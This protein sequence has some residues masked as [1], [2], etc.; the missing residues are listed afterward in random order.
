[1]EVNDFIS[2]VEK[3]FGFQVDTL[4]RKAND[5]A[6]KEVFANFYFSADIAGC[7]PVQS[8]LVL[9]GT[10]I[11]RLRELMGG[12][13]AKNEA[14]EDTM[15]DLVNYLM[16]LKHLKKQ[17]L[18]EIQNIDIKNYWRGKVENTLHQLSV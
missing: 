14:V 4:K 10:K 9:I 17:F 13:Q 3:E 11:A 6:N 8:C 2:E 12:K 16:I 18:E 1:M 5:Y 7:T 15:L